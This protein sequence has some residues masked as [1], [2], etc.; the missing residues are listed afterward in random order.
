MPI[1][2][3]S[4]ATMGSGWVEARHAR[5]QTTLAGLA[6]GG[7]RAAAG[8]S[9]TKAPR[10]RAVRFSAGSGPLEGRENELCHD[11]PSLGVFIGGPRSTNPDIRARDPRDRVNPQQFLQQPALP[12]GFPF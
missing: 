4:A 10:R 8:T 7:G 2:S 6:V 12:A 3:L 9:G 5:S 1:G 11:D